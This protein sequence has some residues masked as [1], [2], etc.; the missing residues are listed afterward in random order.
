MA[1][2]FRF[3][4][5]DLDILKKFNLNSSR[6]RDMTD[7]YIFRDKRVRH[8]FK[9]KNEQEHFVL[10]TAEPGS[11]IKKNKAITKREANELVKGR[12]L[13]VEKKGIGHIN[14]LDVEGYAEKIR[15]FA[16]NSKGAFID[17]IQIEFEESNKIIPALTRELEPLKVIRTGIFDYA[18]NN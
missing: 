3:V 11:R 8:Y 9:T 17:E 2:E 13:V 14:V 4:V 16:G 5:K 12:I 6:A 15:M 18:Q 7:Y 10:I 1:E